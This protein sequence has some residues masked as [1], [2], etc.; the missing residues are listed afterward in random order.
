MPN[1]KSS[2][3]KGPYARPVVWLP[4]CLCLGQ[5][6]HSERVAAI[7]IPRSAL[8]SIAQEGEKHTTRF[9]LHNGHSGA[10]AVLRCFGER[11][12][13]SVWANVCFLGAYKM[14]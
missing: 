1:V 13:R 12:S 6:E 2:E 10:A 4:V 14:P 7:H 11:R 3:Q 8:V 5:V 9:L